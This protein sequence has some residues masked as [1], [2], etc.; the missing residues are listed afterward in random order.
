MKR[1]LTFAF[2]CICFS[3]WL[4]AQTIQCHNRPEDNEVEIEF[5]LPQFQIIDTIL[6]SVYEN[7]T[8]FNWIRVEDGDFGIIDSV[9]MPC[10]PQLTFS[11]TIPE[12]A[13]DII[14]SLDDSVT[15]YLNIQRQIIPYQEDFSAGDTNYQFVFA[16]NSAF[17]SSYSSFFEE[18]LTVLSPFRIREKT[19]INISIF[20]FRYNPGNGELNILTYARISLKYSVDGGEQDYPISQ[21]FDDYYSEVFKNYKSN[22]YTDEI[23]YLIVTPKRFENALTPFVEYKQ[24]LGYT[25]DVE[26]IAP[27]DM[28]AEVVKSVIQARYDIQEL[29]P[30]YILLVGDSGDLPPAQGDYSGGDEDDPITDVSYVLLEGDDLEVDAFIGRWPVHGEFE[31]HN[32]IRKTIYMEMNMKQLEKKALLV[33]GDDCSWFVP[34]FFWRRS[35]DVG[36]ENVRVQSFIPN[37]FNCELRWQPYLQ[38]VRNKMAWNP[39]VF[40][41][42]GHGSISSMGTLYCDDNEDSYIRDATINEFDNQTYPMVFSFAC[43]TGNFAG[44]G[45]CI[46]ESWIRST[47]GGATYVGSSV[48]TLCSSDKVLE[49]GILGDTFTGSS[50]RSIASAIALG[51]KYYREYFF[52]WCEDRR[53]RFTKSYNLLGDPSFRIRGTSCPPEYLIT[54]D[55]L[56]VG[57]VKEYHAANRIYVCNGVTIASGEEM[58]LS[59]GEE[60][61]FEDGFESAN[62]SELDAWIEGCNIVDLAM[63]NASTSSDGI[64]EEKTNDI[65]DIL[66][67]DSLPFQLYPNPTNGEFKIRFDANSTDDALFLMYNMTGKMVVEKTISIVRKGPQEVR[68]SM[69]KSLPA[70]IYH[71]VFKTDGK[72][73]YKKIVKQ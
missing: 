16:Q 61:V 14:C 56:I 48:N 40:V 69:E 51:K 4:D 68:M 63:I 41:Y 42:S 55:Y 57:D 3:S 28:S 25:V 45:N 44:A 15:D 1:F 18:R 20:P 33:S 38:T 22:G 54:G 59:A 12:S 27:E 9:G 67:V 11:V 7:N 64:I 65:N 62:G 50:D 29:R 34:Q 24:N 46:G 73:F 35:F 66:D 37:G 23:K 13:Y 6:P 58:Y 26:S 72:T 5:F 30:D 32:I 49:E 10:L 60:I 39:L 52:S 2:V 70:G 21:V 19:G 17:Y 31:L 53:K 43:K 36:N 71:I 8:K 47:K